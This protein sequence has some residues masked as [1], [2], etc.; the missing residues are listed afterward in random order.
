MNTDTT[1]LSEYG[2]TS[3]DKFHTNDIKGLNMPVVFYY[4]DLQIFFET[5]QYSLLHLMLMN[6]S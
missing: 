2:K 4:N 1:A 3:E 5:K 6:S